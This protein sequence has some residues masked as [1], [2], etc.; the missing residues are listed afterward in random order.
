MIAT[1]NAASSEAVK[2]P[3]RSRVKP[4]N[5]PTVKMTLTVPADAWERLCVHATM[6]RRDRNDIVA[7]LIRA[8]LRTYVIQER[9]GRA[10][11]DPDQ[12]ASSAA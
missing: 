1:A 7:E 9:A 3:R 6:L 8:N 4:S 10:E 5:R 2:P 11:A 12:S